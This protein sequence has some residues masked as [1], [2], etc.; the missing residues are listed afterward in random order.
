ME[1]KQYYIKYL[2]NGAVG[3]KT[4]TLIMTTG[5]WVQT[6]FTVGDLVSAF[7]PNTPPNELGQ[8]SLHLPDG[9]ATSTLSENCFAL[10]ETSGTTLD[11]GCLISSLNS[12]GSKSKK[13]LIIRSNITQGI[14]SL[15][16]K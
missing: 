10:T 13:P 12:L 7:F 1:N 14:S 6:L 9:V 4:H 16:T 8:Y 2:N 15:I 5:E 11:P 3:M